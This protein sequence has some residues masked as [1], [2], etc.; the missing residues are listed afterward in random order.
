[1]ARRLYQAM[2]TR[3]ENIARIRDS[4]RLIE[5]SGGRVR[6]TATDTPGLTIVT[7]ELPEAYRPEQFFPELPFFPF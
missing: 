4:I 3:P 1:M 5:R 2:L 6:I 7:L